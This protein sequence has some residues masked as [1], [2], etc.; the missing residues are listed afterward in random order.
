[1]VAFDRDAMA[2][3]QVPYERQIN[4]WSCGAAALTMVYRSL[5]LECRQD[6]IWDAVRGES[7]LGRYCAKAHTLAAH[8]LQRGCQALVIQVRDPWLVLNR[9]M[10]QSIRVII[11]HLP[12]PKSGG[13]HYSVLTSLSD[14]RVSF[15]D[16]SFGPGRTLSR[17]EFLQLW[18]PYSGLTE[19]LGQVLVAIAPDSSQLES[20]SLCGGE[21]ADDI[22]C[23]S[24]LKPFRLQPLAIMGC[25][26]DWC[27]MRAWERFFCPWCDHHWSSRWGGKMNETRPA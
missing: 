9:C 25:L 8:A 4:S 17:N 7:R 1:M 19:I 10:E 22:T 2:E 24:C 15:H 13:G 6:Q 14:D 23:V 11:N 18:N 3:L 27:P 16:P 20:C 5:G 21:S 26:T 12:T